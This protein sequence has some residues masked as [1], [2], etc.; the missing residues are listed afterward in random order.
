MADI[1][2]HV[3]TSCCGHK[4]IA[5]VPAIRLAKLECPKCGELNTPAE[6]RV[7]IFDEAEVLA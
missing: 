7:I 5:V 1:V 6:T 2:M 4:Y 3:I